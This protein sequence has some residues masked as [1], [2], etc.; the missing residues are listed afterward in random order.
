[1]I[2][3]PQLDALSASN[4]AVAELAQLPHSTDAERAAMAK[5][6]PARFGS[7]P[8]EEKTQLR[9]AEPRWVMLRDF[10][11]ACSRERGT[12]VAEVRQKVHEPG[13]VAK[14]ASALATLAAQFQ[15]AR[16]Q[17]AKRTMMMGA[18]VFLG[19]NRLAGLETVQPNF[20]GPQ[21]DALQAQRQ[22]AA[23]ATRINALNQFQVAT[24][25]SLAIGSLPLCN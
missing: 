7:L 14:E 5:S 10:I 24:A 16:E 3:Q 25:N 1:M 21:G 12:A 11:M 13:D 15:A 17:Q 22:Q 19:Q 23:T 2:R 4:D 18:M 6:L 9:E 20:G 8:D